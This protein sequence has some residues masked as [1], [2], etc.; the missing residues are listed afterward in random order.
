MLSMLG[1]VLSESRSPV[2]T[3]LYMFCETQLHILPV[4]LLRLY[5]L[6]EL[7]L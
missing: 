3:I 7:H 5:G 1:A 4:T 6:S 2:Y